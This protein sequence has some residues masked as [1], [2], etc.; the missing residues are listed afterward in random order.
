MCYR[1]TPPSRGTA[2]IPARLHQ[3]P[4]RMATERLRRGRR[5]IHSSSP[6]AVVEPRRPQS[7]RQRKLDRGQGYKPDQRQP[8]VAAGGQGD[9]ANGLERSTRYGD[10][11]IGERRVA[12][13]RHCARA[14]LRQHCVAWTA[15]YRGTNGVLQMMNYQSRIHDEVP[16]ITGINRP[17]NSAQAIPVFFSGF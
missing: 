13:C 9:V 10:R 4:G 8:S 17:S 16:R 5:R 6:S 14:S 3:G 15:G 11:R 1:E 7:S 2:V 12:E